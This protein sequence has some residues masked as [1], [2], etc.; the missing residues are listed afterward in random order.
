MK[1][2][3]VLQEWCSIPKRV[4][5][6]LRGLKDDDLT[7]RGGSE[8][9]SIAESVHHLV[10]S[11]L[12]TS[13]VVLA[14]LGKPGCTYDWSWV[15]PDRAWMTRLSYDRAPIE[16]ALELLES[17]TRHISSLVRLGRGGLRRHVVIVDAPG[18]PLRRSTVAKLLRDEVTHATHHL[19]DIQS[20]KRAGR[21]TA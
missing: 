14:A 16:P 17:L 4:R 6:L 18:A 15:T 13:H 20:A 9:W 8:G 21:P 2:S 12:I 19:G 5:R 10:E 11:N 3:P 1:G 7:M